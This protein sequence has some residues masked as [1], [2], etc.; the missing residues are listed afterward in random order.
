MTVN[1]Q[2]VYVAS[3]TEGGKRGGSHRVP[4]QSIN[5]YIYSCPWLCQVC[6]PTMLGWR[7]WNERVLNVVMVESP[8]I[9]C[10]RVRSF[11][12]LWMNTTR[13]N[14]ER[15]ILSGVSSPALWSFTAKLTLPLELGSKE[16]AIPSWQHTYS[17]RPCRPSI[18]RQAQHTS[19]RQVW[20]HLTYGCSQSSKIHS[21]EERF[22]QQ[23]TISTSLYDPQKDRY[24]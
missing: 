10:Q 1:A 8:V 16:L 18:P 12:A 5:S 4:E 17:F 24:R 11:S 23:W 9:C 3:K 14:N 21:K 20:F 13:L 2:C 19:F 7:G 22:S 15:R 6:F